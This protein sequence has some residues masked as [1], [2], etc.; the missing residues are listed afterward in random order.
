[1]MSAGV[2]GLASA[3]LPAAGLSVTGAGFDL[4]SATSCASAEASSIVAA[5]DGLARGVGTGSAGLVAAAT[6]VGSTGF[7]AG[8][9]APSSSSSLLAA[10]GAGFAFN[11][12]GKKIDFPA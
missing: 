2:S 9:G 4:C 8:A 11:K 1:M 12:G 10:A 5:T 6:T 7:A 3:D